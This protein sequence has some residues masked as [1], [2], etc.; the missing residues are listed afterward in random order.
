VKVT[1]KPVSKSNWEDV[2]RLSVY[3]KQQHYVLPV[4]VSLSKVYVKPDDLR[5]FPYAIYSGDSIVGFFL[6]KCDPYSSQNYWVEGFLIDKKFQNMGYGTLALKE[7]IT[8]V[9]KKFKN[10]KALKAR[11]EPN[12]KAAM[13]VCEKCKMKNTGIYSNG[14]EIYI[15]NINSDELPKQEVA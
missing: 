14:E 4:S 5:F 10:S 6:V 1:V 7:A 8:Q 11:V 3:P 12:N 15:I 9:S 13:R 2:I